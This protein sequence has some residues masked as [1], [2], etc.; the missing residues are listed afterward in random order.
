M[1]KEEYS[2][3]FLVFWAAYPRRWIKSSDRYVKI[4]KEDAWTEWRRLSEAEQKWAMYSVKFERTTEFIPDAHRWLKHKRFK[5]Y[6]Y[7]KPVVKRE[8]IKPAKDS[9]L[10]KSDLVREQV[11]KL[12]KGMEM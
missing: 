11:N 2:K 6:D 10:V 1:K 4:G 5:D 7:V 9:E 3:E 8:S 12:A